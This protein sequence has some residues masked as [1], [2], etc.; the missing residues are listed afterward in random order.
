MPF[1]C[2]NRDHQFELEIINLHFES[3]DDTEQC[4]VNLIDLGNLESL[5][6][7]QN[8]SNLIRKLL[9]ITKSFVWTRMDSIPKQ[10][11]NNELINLAGDTK[12]HFFGPL[13]AFVSTLP[14]PLNTF[15]SQSVFYFM[16]I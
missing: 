1:E 16:S 11:K 4:P 8:F 12:N 5:E 6:I 10:S 7:D 14:E 9:K 15:E 2:S 3:S 13:K